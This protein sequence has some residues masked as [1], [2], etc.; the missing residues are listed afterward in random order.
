MMRR[1]SNKPNCRHI[2]KE[3]S[4]QELTV[5][6]IGSVSGGMASFTEG[7]IAIIGIGALTVATFG[8][9]LAVGGACLY[10]GYLQG[11]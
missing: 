4:M 9:G 3:I 10:L 8:F 5:D 1:G 2:Q 7:G 6:Q 11:S